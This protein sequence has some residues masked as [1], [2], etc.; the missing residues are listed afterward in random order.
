MEYNQ[1][2][3]DNFYLKDHQFINVSNK[4]QSFLIRV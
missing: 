3:F 1:S 2:Q 4:K